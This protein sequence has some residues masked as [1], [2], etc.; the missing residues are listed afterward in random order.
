[1]IEKAKLLAKEKHEDQT[2]R[3]GT[4]FDNHIMKV[5]EKTKQ[6]TRDPEVLVAAILHD[7]VEDTDVKITEVRKEFGR[8]VADL[9]WRLT[10][11]KGSTR[12]E[13]KA[14]TYPKIKADKYAVLV[15]LADRF[16]NM[17]G[18]LKLERY[19]KEYP[20]FK[21]NLYTKGVWE[22]FWKELDKLA[23]VK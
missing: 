21:E 13:K 7:V 11:E 17:S 12:D 5:M 8:R 6:Y 22:S 3:G 23:G 16:V 2:Y 15:K 1:M 14:K 4:Y 20:A 9:V 10:D 19:K 18:S